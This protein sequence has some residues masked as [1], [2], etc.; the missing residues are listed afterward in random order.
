MMGSGQ[1]GERCRCELYLI[2]IFI[3]IMFLT[4]AY[5]VAAAGS[6]PFLFE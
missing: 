3:Q 6:T 1:N 2:M 4:D 5:C